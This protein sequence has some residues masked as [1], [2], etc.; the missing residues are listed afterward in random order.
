VSAAGNSAGSAEAFTSQDLPDLSLCDTPNDTI[1]DPECPFWDGEH[2]QPDPFLVY[3]FHRKLEESE[4]GISSLQPPPGWRGLPTKG[5]VRIPVFLVDF[6]D[7]PHDPNQTAVDVQ[8]KMFGNGSGDFPYESLKKYYQRSSY[9]QLTITGDVYDWYRADY[10]RSY[11]Q[12]LGNPA[13]RVTLINEILQKH[14]ALVNFADYD[15]DHN[16]KMDALF[17]KWAGADTGWATFWWASMSTDNSPITVDGV[18]PYKYVWSWYSKPVNGTYY[19]R[20]DIHET[21]H[22]LG[23]PDY[24]DYD[25]GTGP[26]GGIGGWDMMDANWGDHNAFSKYLLGWIDPIVINSG[27]QEVNLPPSST[28]SSENAVLIMPGAVPDSFGEFFLVQY[29]EP[30]TGNDPLKAGLGNAVWIWHVDSTL[31][32]GGWSY[33]YDNSYTS[34]KMLRLMEADGLEE[35]E[36]GTGNWDV[37]D[38]YLPGRVLGPVTVPDSTTYSGLATDVTI[39]PLVQINSSMRVNFSIPFT[40]PVANFTTNRTTGTPPLAVQFTDTSSGTGIEAWAWDFNNDTIIDS[41]S[42]NPAY[43]YA[44]PGT[45]SVNLTVTG[46]GG[47]DTEKKT[48]CINVREEVPSNIGIYRDGTWYLDYNGNGSWDAGT[49]KV[50]NFGAVGWSPVLGDWNGNGTSKIGLYRDGTWYLDY[51]GNGAWDAGTDKVYNFGAVGWS[52]VLGDWNGNGTTNLGV[53]LNGFWY[54][55]YNGN[56]AWDTGIDNA[57]TF[58]ASG[59][60]PVIGDWNRDSRTDIGVYLNGMWYRDFNGNS[61]WDADF[62]NAYTFGMTG[63]SPVVGKWG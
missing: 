12:S 8:S 22:L 36:K 39:D 27:T 47:S 26:K 53:Y 51:N 28:I 2:A 37:D 10:P 63:W 62:D 33:L 9:N 44:S 48:H 58:G 46:T 17:V 57:Y 45:Y 41:T 13:G 23:L 1:F 21:G 3:D 52:P 38:F 31:S 20:V 61:I 59:W 55:D 35:I 32:A 50:Y 11:Y 30:G 25:A 24:Y 43:T 16:G 54:R 42:R 5:T 15:T 40:A 56:G 18:K 14:D 49:D 4:F 7:A 29:R 6:S 19:P 34:H 60:I